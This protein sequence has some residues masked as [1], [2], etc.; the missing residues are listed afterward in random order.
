MTILPLIIFYIFI[1]RKR[2]LSTSLSYQV[3]TCSISVRRM[4]QPWNI[5]WNRVCGFR[6]LW[7]PGYKNLKY[8]LTYF[9][10]DLYHWITFLVQD[11]LS[12]FNKEINL[13]WARDVIWSFRI[14]HPTKVPLVWCGLY[15]IVEKGNYF[16]LQ[17][18]E[19]LRFLVPPLVGKHH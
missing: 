18:I 14:R 1:C 10:D 9:M 17:M 11:V 12:I 13:E 8:F 19:R 4:V 2:I 6:D 15:E 3:F 7:F 16:K 5:G